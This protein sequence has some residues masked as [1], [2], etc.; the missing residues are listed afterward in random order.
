MIF[1]I[2]GVFEKKKNIENAL[3]LKRHTNGMHMARQIVLMIED[4]PQNS[5]ILFI[6]GNRKKRTKYKNNNNNHEGDDESK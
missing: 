4:I 3:D 2:R 1:F 5:H 6:Q